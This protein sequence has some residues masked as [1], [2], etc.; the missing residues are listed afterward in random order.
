[1]AMRM[2]LLAVARCRPVALVLA[3]GTALG[4]RPE[5]ALPRVLELAL[6]R[7]VSPV[8]RR[9]G[10]R[11]AQAVRTELSAPMGRSVGRTVLG[12][13]LAGSNCLG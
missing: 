10:Q 12:R 5:V 8:R 11:L 7:M 13:V 2:V 4:Q 1:M 3:Q 6:G 9:S